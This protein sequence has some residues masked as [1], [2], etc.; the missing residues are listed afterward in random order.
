MRETTLPAVLDVPYDTLD[1][2]FRSLGG[3]DSGATAAAAAV[4]PDTAATLIDDLCAEPLDA[5][6]LL[7]S[8]AAVCAT[9]RAAGV[10]PGAT[11]AVRV[12][13]DAASVVALLAAACYGT[14]VLAAA[15]AAGLPEGPF[16]IA[17]L[18][19][20]VPCE[21]EAPVLVDVSDL[22]ALKPGEAAAL[23]V[24][25]PE[26]P[27]LLLCTS[28]TTGDPKWVRLAHRNLVAAGRFI[29]GSLGL[30]PA[31]LGLSMMPL[32]HGHGIT[33]GVLAPLFS[34]GGFVI[35]DSKDLDFLQEGLRR[36][37]TWYSA[38]PSLHRSL[39]VAERSWPQWFE[40]FRPRVIRSTSE[41]LPAAEKA[42]M[43]QAFGAPVIEAYALTE[44][45]G[46]V[47]TQVHGAGGEPG[48]MPPQLGVEVETLGEDGR[49]TPPG[50]SGRIRVRGPNVMLG[51]LGHDPVGPGEWYQTS[52]LGVVRA[53]G[54]VAVLGRD[55]EAIKRGGETVVP[56]VVESLVEE[57]PDIEQARVCGMPDESLGE[58]ICVAVI[59]PRGAADEARLLRELRV[60][61]PPHLTPSKLRVV[62]EF[63]AGPGKMRRSDLRPLFAE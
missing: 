57:H 8:V 37:S 9:L 47:C 3:A 46:H 53:D 63:P 31:D 42:A 62:A 49:P 32:H 55:S 29:A 25:S 30:T 13:Q 20:A 10:E 33:A 35:L 48:W 60:Q 21:D 56:A 38:A 15:D 44:V 26:D 6:R 11:I 61:L 58:Q 54:A 43:Q 41:A 7:G 34:G 51:Y 14:A 40:D 50:E 19:T 5:G 28:G 22:E 39:L 45:P 16:E 59:S 24:R 27:A 52:D 4:T 1:G 2:Y 17:A 36:E 23:P 18:V 12:G